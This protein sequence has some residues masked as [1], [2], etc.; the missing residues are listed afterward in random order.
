MVAKRLE[1]LNS[2]KLHGATF[3]VRVI[4]YV[5]DYYNKLSM[6]EQTFTLSPKL[7]TLYLSDHEIRTVLHGAATDNCNSIG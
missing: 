7:K 3:V 5:S 4:R 6:T 2:Y 1:I